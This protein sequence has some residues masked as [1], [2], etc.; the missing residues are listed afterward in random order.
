MYRQIHAHHHTQLPPRRRR[1]RLPLRLRPGRRGHPLRPARPGRPAGPRG[2][3]PRP[4]PDRR[5]GVGG[6][7]HAR[8]RRG[9]RVSGPAPP[10]GGLDRRRRR[11]LGGHGRARRRRD[12]RR[13]RE[14]GP[15]GVRLHGPRRH[16]G[17]APHREP[18]L[19]RAR[20]A[21]VRGPVRAHPDR[22]VRDG[23]PPSHARVR[24]DPGA[25][26]GGGRAGTGERGA[27]PGGDVPRADHRRRRP[28]RP[29]DRGPVHQAALLHPQRR[30]LRGA[31]GGRGVRRGLPQGPGL[32][33]RH[34]RARLAHH[35]VR[36]GGL[37]GLPGGRQRPAGLRTGGRPA[38]RRRP[39][40][41]LRRLHLHDPGDPGGPG[42]LCE[43]RGRGVRPGEGPAAGEHGRRRALGLP[44][45]DAGAV[46][47]GGGGAA[48]ARGGAGTP[49]APAGRLPAGAGGGL[50][51][52]GWFCSSGT[53]V[54]GRG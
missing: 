2:Q 22:Q 51:D 4:L 31:A 21:P 26:R 19:R 45:G 14:R 18:L 48:A 8:P 3:R 53:V 15:A 23:R 41:D 9:R 30:R 36:V 44:P 12:R 49:G 40:R 47:A 42:L 43:G 34:G 24:H 32:G 46:P 35:D 1:R 6:P 17:A 37:H 29:D 11:H 54:L 25:A 33:A 7:R 28:G 52:G 50:G 39:R 5:P 13:P 27:Q 16:P 10:L 38:R 20:P